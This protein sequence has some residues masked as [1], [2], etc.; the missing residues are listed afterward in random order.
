MPETVPIIALNLDYYDYYVTGSFVFEEQKP[1]IQSGYTYEENSVYYCASATQKGVYCYTYARNN[2]LAYTD[3]SGDFIQY[4]FG[5]IVGGFSGYQIGKA[6]GA[7]GWAMFGYI[8]GGAGIGALSAGIGT[9]VTTAVGTGMTAA[10]ASCAGWVGAMAGSTVSGAFSGAAFAGLAGGNPLDGLWKGALTGLAG[11]SIGPLIG[12]APGAIV[13]GAMSGAVSSA[14]NGG[15]WKDV[16]ISAL[17]GGGVAWGSYEISQAIGYGAYKKAYGGLENPPGDRWNY[18]QYRAASVAAQRSFARGVEGGGWILDKKM[19][20]WPYGTKDGIE[21]TDR[22][23]GVKGFF[24]THPNKGSN[25]IPEHGANDFNINNNN[26]HFGL[27]SY[28]IERNNVYFHTPFT[29]ES[30]LLFSSVSFNPYPY[31]YYPFLH[32][33]LWGR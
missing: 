30:R 24:H 28:V 25:W 31:Y 6:A 7:K 32:L 4:I 16:G 18:R 14:L 9:A 27:P 8:M 20:M 15:G 2:P 29:T 26:P 11:S 12:G 1:L 13:S 5:A 33:N 3:P 17:L 10:G 22:P 21:A 19:S 23:D